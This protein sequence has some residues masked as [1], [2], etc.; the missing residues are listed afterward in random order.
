MTRLL[1]LAPLALLLTGFGEDPHRFKPTSIAF[2]DRD[3]GIVTG[4]M[5]EACGGAHVTRGRVDVQLTHD[6]G[7]TW[8]R[9]A[10]VCATGDVATAGGS[11]AIVPIEDGLLV[12][13]D[14]GRTWSTVRTRPADGVSFA[15]EEEGW[16]T[17]G[18]ELTW[19][20]EATDD[21][22]RT[23]RHVASRC[24]GHAE[25]AILSRPTAEHGWIICLGRSATGFESK[26][27]F[28]TTD[29]GHTWQLRAAVDPFT[30]RPVVGAISAYGYP[31][32]IAMLA[33]G[34]GMIWQSRGVLLATRDAGATWR[35]LR[36]VDGEAT[37]VTGLSMLAGANAYA[38][39]WNP[40]RQSTILEHTADNGRTWRAV[41]AWPA[42]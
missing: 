27:V 34:T 20:L 17:R 13:R 25:R 42:G 1:L 11:S 28:E 31:A 30:H 8:R 12:T 23:W 24:E 2:W 39:E 37:V 26:R 41:H 29:G 16:A 19:R 40:D 33:H 15:T 22:G 9:V 32:G 18:F 7:K 38:L 3:H 5:N 14:R 6:G 4:S 35:A 10:T 36:L 21:G